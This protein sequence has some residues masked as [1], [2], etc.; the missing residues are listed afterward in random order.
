ML[1]GRCHQVCPV[2][3]DTVGIRIASRYID[4]KLITPSYSYLDLHQADSRRADI[5]Y[6][7]GC[8]GHLT[9]A[10]KKSMVKILGI[11][12]EK[13]SFMDAD[14]S[15][16]CGRPLIM[17]GLHEAASELINK[18]TGIIKSSGAHTFVTS[19]PICFKVFR[20]EY[21]LPGV[22]VLH[23]SQYLLRLIDNGKIKVQSGSVTAVYH[24]PCELGRGSGVYDEPRLL[25]N[26]VLKLREANENREHS[27]CCGGSIGDLAMNSKERTIVRN[28][29]LKILLEPEPDMLVTACPLCKK[30]FDNDS[31][32]PVKDLAEVIADSLI[33]EKV[34]KVPQQMV[35]AD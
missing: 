7:A 15:V 18:N 10:V 28:E 31:D 35:E 25:L 30:T 13:F 26:K 1:C 9:P 6:F 33:I 32:V 16:C 11:S 34:P 12:G 21:K 19:C 2:Q 29:A 27:L 5:L 14:G 22:E 3:I 20:E 24:D 23:H 8:M 17:A 4:N